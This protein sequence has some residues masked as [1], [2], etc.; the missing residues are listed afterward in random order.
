MTVLSMFHK[1]IPTPEPVRPERRAYLAGQ[2]MAQLV[3]TTIALDA[4]FSRD[5]GVWRVVIE[6]VRE[7]RAMIAADL[8][9]DP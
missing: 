6:R 9:L 2:L 8:G 1:T 7:H 5:N 3:N 4:P